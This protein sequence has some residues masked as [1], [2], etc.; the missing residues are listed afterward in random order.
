MQLWITGEKQVCWYET[1][2]ASH[3]SKLAD[4]TQY[5]DSFQ[6]ITNNTLH[7]V[8]FSACN[9]GKG[10]IIYAYHFTP[11]NFYQL[12]VLMEKSDH[13]FCDY[14]YWYPF[15]LNCLCLEVG[16][17]ANIPIHYRYL[18]LY[19]LADRKIKYLLFQMY[20]CICRWNQHKI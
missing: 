10:L 6:S 4:I 16:Y 9:K 7:D 15:Q 5:K 3:R 11:T 18:I 19:W 17:R 13:L 20:C 2:H 14:G 8:L 1:W 12:F